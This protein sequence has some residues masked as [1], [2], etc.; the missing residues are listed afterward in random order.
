MKR[1]LRNAMLFAALTVVPTAAHAGWVSTWSNTAV[2]QNGDRTGKQDVSMSISNGRVRVDQDDVITLIDYNTGR[3]SLLNPTKNFFWSGTVDEYVR[4]MSTARGS[5]MAEKYG[6]KGMLQHKKH[7]KD[8]APKAYVPPKVDVAKLPP[9]SVTKTGLTA[10]VAGYD[11]EKYDIHANGE[12]FQEIWVAPALD[13][14]SD[15]NFDSFLAVQRKMG[16]A[17][18]GKSA[19]AYNA[20][21]VNEDY[22]KLLEKA[23]VLKAITHHIA[24]GYERAATSI[25][26]A[27]VPADQFTVPE[28]YRKVRLS[29]VLTSPPPEEAPAAAKQGS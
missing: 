25:Q 8:K 22:R 2:K 16:A 20:L 10:K 29:D 15:L 24:G 6:D 14:S 3:Y 4:E 21:Y 12:L 17:R 23:F 27:E 18:K 19:D 26:Q 9:L 13:L 28:R 7:A 5:K 1:T 11:T